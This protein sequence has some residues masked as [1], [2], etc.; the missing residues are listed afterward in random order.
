[1]RI[2]F[3]LN[4]T[5]YEV[6]ANTLSYDPIKIGINEDKESKNFGN[7]TEKNLG[8]FKNL[9]DACKRCIREEIGT[10]EDTVSLMNFTNVVATINSQLTKQLSVIEI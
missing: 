8:Y 3:I 2:Q 1:M 6:D 4:A 5:Q 7:R 10:G 9:T